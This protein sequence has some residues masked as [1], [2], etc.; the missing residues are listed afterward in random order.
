MAFPTGR[1]YHIGQLPVGETSSRSVTL[2]SWSL[3]EEVDDAEAQAS[4][5]TLCVSAMSHM[6]ACLEQHLGVHEGMQAAYLN[7]S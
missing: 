1:S 5:S 2:S 4:S 6:K 3:Q 7:T